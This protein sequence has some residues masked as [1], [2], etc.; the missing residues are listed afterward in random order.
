MA[1]ELETLLV[2]LR[3]DDTQYQ[4]LLKAALRDAQQTGADIRKSL[5]FQDIGA[6]LGG[7]TGGGG[8]L[9]ALKS[10]ASETARVNGETR[11]F[12]N[13]L[14]RAGVSQDGFTAQLDTTAG[15]VGL[16][17]EQL[18][19]AATPLL[20]MGVDA[21]LVDQALLGLASSAGIAGK[22]GRE[23]GEAVEAGGVGLATGRSELLETS[24]VVINASQA[25]AQYAE[26][27]GR[28]VGSLS[29][30]E[31]AIA[32]VKAV[33]R[34]TAP[35]VTDFAD[36]F[37]EL[38]QTES[39]AARE[40]ATARR[41]IGAFAQQGLIPLNRGMA[42]ALAYFNELP[43]DVQRAATAFVAGG[44]GATALAAGAGTL[45]LVLGPLAGPSGVFI[46]AAAGVAALI[47][48]LNEAPT[49]VRT[50]ETAIGDL[51]TAHEEYER[52]VGNASE[53]ETRAAQSRLTNSRD[54]AQA[55]LDE[56][57]AGLGKAQQRFTD[58]ESTL[59]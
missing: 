22:T 51:K 40:A 11:S 7:L 41:E 36:S 59:R 31:K 12:L 27:A 35:D 3:L 53:A 34:E 16:L 39:A 28:S 43:D 46:L 26:E 58:A 37:G 48:S 49:P 52:A 56:A 50:L 42:S 24:N 8:I 33:I 20:K 5:S 38:A 23:L 47:T 17:R 19:G 55:A 15:R 18:Q 10:M 44:A 6:N 1:T 45:A 4:R 2:A 13:T 9:Y 25:W 29:D 57:R 21:D 14:E 32:Y 30:Q 54:T